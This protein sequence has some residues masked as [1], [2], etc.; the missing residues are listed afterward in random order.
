MDNKLMLDFCEA[1]NFLENHPVFI[2]KFK[3]ACDYNTVNVD[4][5][6]NSI[7]NVCICWGDKDYAKWM[8]KYKINED[9]NIIEI[10]FEEFYGHPWTFHHVNIEM[11]LSIPIPYVYGNSICM[12]YHG[13]FDLRVSERSFEECV[14]KL[15]NIVR[16]HY[17]EYSVND[18]EP[19]WVKAYNKKIN[20]IDE[21]PNNPMINQEYILLSPID[22]YVYWLHNYGNTKL[23]II[24]KYKPFYIPDANTF[25]DDNYMSS[26]EKFMEFRSKQLKDTTW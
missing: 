8:S 13:D 14:I 19:E 21:N 23:K 10:P 4:I 18:I 7:D 24:E 25:F 9:V 3:V 2:D 16:E 6:N 12:S 1:L 5:N 20:L 26:K 11:E 15:S 17:G 22:D